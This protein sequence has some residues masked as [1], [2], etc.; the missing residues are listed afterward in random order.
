MPAACHRH[1]T[2][3]T[4]YKVLS[5]RWRTQPQDKV[6]SC[7]YIKK[8]ITDSRQAVVLQLGEADEEKAKDSHR[9]K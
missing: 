4:A 3:T 5:C 8:N 2:V 9:D 6:G 7:G 1:R